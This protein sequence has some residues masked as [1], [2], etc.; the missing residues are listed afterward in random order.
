M[1]AIPSLIM[2]QKAF[3][4]VYRV[5]G[6]TPVHGGVW[7]GRIEGPLLPLISHIYLLLCLSYTLRKVYALENIRDQ[8]HQVGRAEMLLKLGLFC[9]AP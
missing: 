9:S 2:G 6:I 8:L 4:Q 3:P 5:L 7:E 1:H